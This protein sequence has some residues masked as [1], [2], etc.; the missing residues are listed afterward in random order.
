MAETLEGLKC[1]VCAAAAYF[2]DAVDFNKSCEEAHGKFL[3]LSGERIDYVRCCA[4][5]F[6]FAPG[7][8][9][10]TQEQFA[11]KVYNDDYAALDPEYLEV[12][13]QANAKEFIRVF[14]QQVAAIRHLDY[15][16]GDGKLSALLCAA[17]FNS[18]DY[19]PFTT[20]DICLEKIG[21]FNFITAYEVFE[22]VSDVRKLMADLD[23]LL[24]SEGIII[25]STLLSDGYLPA[26]RRLTWWYAS[27]RNGH[28][29]LFSEKSLTVLAQSR[30]FNFKS[31]NE[32]IHIF[33]KKAPAWA[34][35]LSLAPSHTIDA[36]GDRNK[37]C[38]CNSGKKYK[39]CHGVL[40][41]SS[42]T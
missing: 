14:G 27:P 8:G 30:G 38:A 28:I 16:G 23:R 1:P 12:R 35:I 18:S 29:S 4:C 31:F 19:D 32:N 9:A 11:S 33:W 26:N 36:S 10:W 3:P 41:Q 2:F 21:Q 39:H 17:G 5:D 42:P 15:G 37:L 40:V 24:K 13:P 20:K 7:M 6:C 25:F 34:S 22:H